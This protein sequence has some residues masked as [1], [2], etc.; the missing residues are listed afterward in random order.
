MT[1]QAI[2]GLGFGD[3]GKGVVTD[4]LSSKNPKET[5]VIRFSGGQQAGHKVCKKDI[6]HIFSNFGSGTLNGCP[7]YWSKYCTFEPVGFINEWKVLRKKGIFPKIYLHPHCPVTTPYDV[8]VNRQ[9]K[10]E[11]QHGTCGSGIFRT[12]TRH[13]SKGVQLTIEDLMGPDIILEKI[14][15]YY[16][17][18]VVPEEKLFYEAVQ[19]LIVHV[20]EGHVSLAETIP[21]YKHLVF[22]G[23]QGLMLDEHVGVMPHCTPSDVTPR[24]AMK[25]A[26]LDTVWL[27]TRCY[28]T[29]HGNG[30]LANEL[31]KP[32]LK[33][34]E[35]ETNHFNQFQGEFRIAILDLGVLL[36]AKEY[37]VN[38]VIHKD[39]KTN[40]VVTCMDQPSQFSITTKGHR[41]SFK[42]A[43]H[44]AIYLGTELA[45]NG[46]IYINDSLYSHTCRRIF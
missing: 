24:N 40:L 25:L 2:I 8:L 6:E 26:K 39:T 32:I 29:R 14:R 34:T 33:N 18:A 13:F 21:E 36:H 3:E 9:N 11:R 28:G 31:S 44:M 10:Q 12:R 27:V 41:I 4:S 7:T 35:R 16:Q 37:G 43:K 38:K 17:M 19:D 15:D 23:S 20:I 42:N 5:I 22:E 45:I 30:P 46:E 1:N